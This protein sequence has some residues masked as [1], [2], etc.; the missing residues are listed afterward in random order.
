MGPSTKHLAWAVLWRSQNALDGYRHDFLGT[1]QHPSR[2]IL[3]DT[4][5]QAREFIVAHYGYIR[6]RADLRAEPHGWKMPVPIR[7]TIRVEP[8]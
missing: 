1:N 5:K 6:H 4:R 7:V 8:A 3:F 2:T